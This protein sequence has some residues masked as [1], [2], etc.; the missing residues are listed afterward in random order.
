MLRLAHLMEGNMSRC[1]CS[2]AAAF[3]LS[4][5]ILLALEP[6]RMLVLLQKHVPMWP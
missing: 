5:S 2:F 6:G 1:C 4:L 3:Q